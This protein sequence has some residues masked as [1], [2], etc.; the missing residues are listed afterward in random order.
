M[1]MM[2][3]K[4]MKMTMMNVVIDDHVM[5]M[6]TTTTMSRR[7]RDEGT[8]RTGLES[9]LGRWAPLVV[10]NRNIDHISFVSLASRVPLSPLVPRPGRPARC[11]K[12]KT[13]S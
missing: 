9:R 3:M 12:R 4:T 10:W 13:M 7:L 8:V 2:K 11:G 1:K 5:M 6:T